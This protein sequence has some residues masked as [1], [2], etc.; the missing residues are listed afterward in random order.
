MTGRASDPVDV[1]DGFWQR[2]DTKQ[3]LRARD[4][5]HLFHLLRQYTGA[6]QTRI[7]ITCGG[8]SQ[9][10]V[11]EIM[12]RVGRRVTSIDV[13]ERVADG[14]DLPN[15]ARTTFGLAPRDE[16]EEPTP[17]MTATERVLSVDISDDELLRRLS[18]SAGVDAELVHVLQTET[19]NIR[20][21]DRRFGAQSVADKMN[22]HIAHLQSTL[23]HSLRAS[24]RAP[25]AGVL[26]DA[27]A[28]AGW[29]AVDTC[30]LPQAWHHFERAKAAAREAGDDAL[31]AFAAGEQGYVLLDL[32]R[33]DDAFLLVDEAYKS[34]RQRIPARLRSWLHAARAEMAAA[35]LD[36]A[37]CR[38]A[39]DEAAHVLP[40]G[41][42]DP[43]LPYLALNEAHLTRW[44][45]NCLIQFGDPATADDLRRALD[46]M[47]Q[48]FTRAEA[49]L[50][51]D[52]AQALTAS[53]D[54]DEARMHI[55]QASELARLTDSSRQRRRI[56]RVA[57]TT[58]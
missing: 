26:A 29:Q 49:S 15:E 19:E 53:G 23:S 46:T 34:H 32:G 25:L 50:R 12:K 47:G 51:C 11:S 2:E 20:L 8:M 16:E 44:R 57:A 33:A 38:S 17:S 10:D 41:T 48:S 1:P 18:V 5:G 36:E 45:G 56:E 42:S 22:A 55:N 7:G 13:L 37:G 35:R 39:L 30:S 3:A 52:L 27:S 9:G 4:V 14:F 28:L 58:G 31:C 24:L 6:S 54:A 43:E 21:L 40:E